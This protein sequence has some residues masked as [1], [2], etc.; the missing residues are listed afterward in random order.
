MIQGANVTLMVNNMEKAIEFYTSTLGLKLKARYG[1]NFAQV[2]APGTIIALHPVTEKGPKP[3]RSES[4]SIGF[5]VNDL[6]KSKAELESKG[7]KFSKTTNDT[8]VRLAFFNDPDGNPLY[9]SQSM[10]G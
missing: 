4:I 7:V 8:Q 9:L 5:A 2:E 10:W 3:G 1:D 6:E